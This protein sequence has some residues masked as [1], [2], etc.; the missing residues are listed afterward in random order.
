MAESNASIDQRTTASSLL[1]SFFSFF[2]S[3]ARS[4]RLPIQYTPTYPSTPPAQDVK[5]TP[6]LLNSA[7]KDKKSSWSILAARFSLNCSRAHTSS[8][9]PFIRSKP[10]GLL[11]LPPS[12]VS[13]LLLSLLLLASAVLVLVLVLG[14]P[15]SA[16]YVL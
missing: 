10:L 3:L 9:M 11:P 5:W 13:I 14:L 6:R 15:C 8:M 16:R 1:S 12:P 2:S 7:S 4:K